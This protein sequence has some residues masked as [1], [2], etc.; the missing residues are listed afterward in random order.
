MISVFRK[1]KTFKLRA[2]H[3]QQK[4]GVAGKSCQEVLRKGCIRFQVRRGLGVGR[5][6]PPRAGPGQGRGQLWE[7]AGRL[8]MGWNS[9]T[10]HLSPAALVEPR[11][12]KS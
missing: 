8:W 12:S 10:R 9:L 11:V 1:P 2:L 3:S 6:A 4:F 7:P 5:P